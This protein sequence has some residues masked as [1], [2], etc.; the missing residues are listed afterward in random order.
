MLGSCRWIQT[1]LP[2]LALVVAVA[3][4]NE[5]EPLP[6]GYHLFFANSSEASLVKPATKGGECLAGPHVAELG[7]SGAIIFGRIEPKAGLPPHP[8][9][10]PGYFVIDSATDTKSTGLERAAWLDEL[11]AAGIAAPVLLPP[12]RVWPKKY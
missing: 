11:K 10:A 5:G 3:G 6:N 12:Q 9:H 1:F 2:L 8:D 4:C 7:H